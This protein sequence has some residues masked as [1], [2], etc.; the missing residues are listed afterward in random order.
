L[1]KS[2]AS[3]RTKYY[4]VVYDLKGDKKMRSPAVLDRVFGDH[5]FFQKIIAMLT[6]V[7]CTFRGQT[8]PTSL[9]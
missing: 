6:Q 8:E 2:D 3:Y 1:I 5:I 4:A 9:Q 7:N